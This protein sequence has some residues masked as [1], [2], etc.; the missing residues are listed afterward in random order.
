MRKCRSTYLSKTTQRPSGLSIYQF[1]EGPATGL[2][3]VQKGL[4]VW[5]SCPETHLVSDSN[6]GNDVS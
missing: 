5:S 3:R 2:K 6:L 1:I 4:N